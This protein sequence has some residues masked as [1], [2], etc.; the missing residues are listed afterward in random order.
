MFERLIE[1]VARGLDRLGFPYML[2][3]G[4]AVLLYGS[5]RL[6]RDIDVILGVGPER[7]PELVE[8]VRGNGRQILVET[9]AEFVEK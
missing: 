8:W 3:G 1:T 9:P 7:L 2:I 4:Q 6:T 5:P